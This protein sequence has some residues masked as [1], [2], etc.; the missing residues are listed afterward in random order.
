MEEL[1]QRTERPDR[2]LTEAENR[3]STAEDRSIWQERALGYLLQ[4]EANLTAKCDD[5]ENRL[6][7]NNIRLYGIPEGVEKDDMVSFLTDFLSTS[8]EFQEEVDIKLERAHR[9]LGLKSKAAAAAL[10]SIIA[11][12][13]DFNVKQ[14]R[15]RKKVR[16]VVKKLKERNIRAQSPY[17]AQLRLFLDGGTKL[18]PSLLE[19]HSTLKELQRNIN[20][21]LGNIG[22]GANTRGIDN[23]AEPEEEPTAESSGDQSHHSRRQQRDENRWSMKLSLS[24][25]V[26]A[27]MLQNRQARRQRQQ[28]EQ[29]V[30]GVTGVL[31]DFGGLP[32]TPLGVEVL[33][34]W[35]LLSW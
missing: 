12:F 31:N 6:C 33:H 13:L 29:F 21:G 14:K 19:A 17:P 2:R 8:L 25:V 24:L 16:E 3:V 5:M 7:R 30:A 23:T 27:R 1:K 15:K 22:T 4:R 32:P 9:A 10:R 28:A 26:R 35:Q 34:G 20:G 11:R 18:F